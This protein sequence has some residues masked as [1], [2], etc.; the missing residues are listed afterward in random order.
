MNPTRAYH[1]GR[2]EESVTFPPALGLLFCHPEGRLNRNLKRAICQLAHFT[3]AIASR[4]FV[5]FDV[6]NINYVQGSSPPVS[7][8][9]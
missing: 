1:Q 6:G 7:P 2:Q 9:D 8:V 4:R 5:A 3:N